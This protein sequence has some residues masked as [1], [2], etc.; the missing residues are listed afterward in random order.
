MNI[1]EEFWYG[2]LDPAEYDSCATKEYRE[3]LKLI[4][5]NEDKLLETMTEEQ[6]ELFSRY[7]DCVREFQ[8]KAKSLPLVTLA[9]A[10]T[11]F[12][13]GIFALGKCRCTTIRS[14]FCSSFVSYWGTSY[15]L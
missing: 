5:Q 7:T 11:R 14:I 6:K 12:S 2:N 15:S 1:L 3:S 10:A 13:W 8:T 9:Y 4:S